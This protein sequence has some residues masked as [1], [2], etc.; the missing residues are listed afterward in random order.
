MKNYE[1][2]GVIG[3]GAYGVVLKAKRR[4]SGETVAIKQFKEADDD[5]AIGRT[6]AR[7]VRALRAL[8]HRNVVEL[9]EA[10]RRRGVVHLVF[11][12]VGGNLLEA[13]ERVPRGFS[14]TAIARCVQ[15]ALEG[16]RHMHSLGFLHRD[17]KPENLLLDADGTLKIC[18]MGFAKGLLD[19]PLTD[20]VATRWYRPPELLLGVPY[21]TAIDIWAVGCIMAELCDTQPLFPGTDEVNQLSLIVAALGTLP[22]CLMDALN[23]HSAFK[24]V[25]LPPHPNANDFS[26]YRSK[27]TEN[28]VDLLRHMLSLDP[29]KRITADDALKHP[30]FGITKPK[31]QR[32]LMTSEAWSARRGCKVGSF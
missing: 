22:Q 26:R 21:T 29:S 24:G 13:L 7:E 6:S 4:D 23:A 25:T 2:V 8:E 3:E 30:Y 32:L 20:Y 18:D 9:R 15:Q 17:I 12:Y 5:G 1:V 10:F 14:R 16:L 19:G 28:G 31:V 11:E 27:L